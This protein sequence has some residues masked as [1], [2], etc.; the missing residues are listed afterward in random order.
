M[1]AL[2]P[3]KILALE[4][5][6]ASTTAEQSSNDRA[7][8]VNIFLLL[9]GGVGTMVIT[10]Y[11]VDSRLQLSP[12]MLMGI[13]FALA[14]IGHSF[15]FKLIRLRQAWRE[16][17]KA[18]NQIKDHYI[19]SHPSTAAAFRWRTHTIPDAGKPWSIT[20]NLCLLI[21]ILDSLSLSAAV[22]FA[23][24]AAGADSL[25]LYF[26]PEVL[27]FVLFVYLQER[28]YTYQMP[29]K[30][31]ILFSLWGTKEE[32]FEDGFLSYFLNP[33]KRHH[34]AK[35]AH[36]PPRGSPPSRSSAAGSAPPKAAPARSTRSM[37][38]KKADSGSAQQVL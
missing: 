5:N 35:E 29:C 31:P 36:P 30:E 26:A 18:M 14:L 21:V 3:E 23:R 15:V 32:G 33:A 25:P 12:I 24:A 20:F 7:A 34:D 38:A 19:R 6:Y 2:S 28:F 16:S 9:V 27:A 22:F 4:F 17:T 1:A 11:Q 13:F 37:S 10:S 8:V